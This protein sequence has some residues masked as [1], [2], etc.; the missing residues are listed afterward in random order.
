MDRLLKAKHDAHNVLIALV[1]FCRI[2]LLFDF[3]FLNNHFK[4]KKNDPA[5]ER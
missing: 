1:V 3:V 2:V 4:I 5:N